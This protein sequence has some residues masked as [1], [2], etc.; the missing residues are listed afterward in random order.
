MQNEIVVVKYSRNKFINR[1][2]LK[3]FVIRLLHPQFRRRKLVLAHKDEFQIQQTKG[4]AGARTK[5]KTM[6]R[7]GS[8]RAWISLPALLCSSDSY[9]ALVARSQNKSS[10]NRQQHHR[11]FEAAVDCLAQPAD[12]QGPQRQLCHWR[13]Y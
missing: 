6:E 4:A 7:T 8:D 13:Q 2:A 1:F 11:S 10:R 12:E 3:H 5:I 9:Y